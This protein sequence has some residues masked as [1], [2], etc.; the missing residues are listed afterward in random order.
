M[1]PYLNFLNIKELQMF[2]EHL[3]AQKINTKPKIPTAKNLMGGEA[4]L[5]FLA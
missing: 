1:Y 5:T 4:L 2:Y 3:L